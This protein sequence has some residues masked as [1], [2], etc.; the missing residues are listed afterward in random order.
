MTNGEGDKDFH[1][2]ADFNCFPLIAYYDNNW[3]ANVLSLKD[4][5]SIEVNKIKKII[6]E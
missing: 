4:T 3:I 6:Q 1:Q 5:S 2:D